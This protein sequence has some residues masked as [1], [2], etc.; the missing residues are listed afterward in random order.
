MLFSF[1]PLTIAVHATP[2]IDSFDQGTYEIVV[3]DSLLTFDE[4][5]KTK[6]VVTDSDSDSSYEDSDEER[7]K[8]SQKLFSNLK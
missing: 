6:P 8:V 3:N 2:E 7:A 1:L 5:R 4:Q